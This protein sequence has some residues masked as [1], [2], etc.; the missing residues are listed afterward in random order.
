MENEERQYE[1]FCMHRLDHEELEAIEQHNRWPT[2]FDTYERLV[3]IG[4]QPVCRP[5]GP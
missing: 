3:Q 4:A 5:G 2:D 1:V